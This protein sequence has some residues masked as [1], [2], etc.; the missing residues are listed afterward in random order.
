MAH[1]LTHPLS[2]QTIE[3]EAEQVPMY[4]SQGWLKPADAKKAT[5]VSK[6]DEK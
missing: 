1:H 3:V 4:L 6:S 5:T 2:D